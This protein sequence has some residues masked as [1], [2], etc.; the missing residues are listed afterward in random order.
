MK[1]QNA[2]KWPNQFTHGWT[3]Q[4][5]EIL[6]LWKDPD[7]TIDFLMRRLP[8]RT[9]RAIRHRLETLRI[10]KPKST[11]KTKEE[12]NMKEMID[13]EKFEGRILST[14]R[15]EKRLVKIP[16]RQREFTGKK[17][18]SA[19]LLLSDLHLGKENYFVDEI[20]KAE[21]TYNT[22]IAT[23]E[24]NRLIESISDINNLL[25]RSYK[26]D[27]LYVFGLGDLI[28]GDIIVSGQRF[29]IEAGAGDQ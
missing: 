24:A 4:E 11:L 20:G 16:P 2:T 21:M 14:L 29:F 26:I 27:D 22:D 19:V 12:K 1:Y 15:Q 8:N 17:E 28:E 7:I 18:E 23:K 25:S 6:Q 3:K 13:L 10:K 9:Y 5:D